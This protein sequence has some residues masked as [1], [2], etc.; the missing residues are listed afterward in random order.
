M[1]ATQLSVRLN[2]ETLSRVDALRIPDRPGEP[3]L[4]RA[5]LLRQAIDIGLDALERSRGTTNPTKEA[6]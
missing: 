5:A 2:A 4:S 1:Q 3:I 6:R